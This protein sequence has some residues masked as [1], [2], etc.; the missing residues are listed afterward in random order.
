MKKF[1][2]YTPLSVLT[3]LL[4]LPAF[5]SNRRGGFGTSPLANPYSLTDSLLPDSLERHHLSQHRDTIGK[6]GADSTKNKV[7]LESPVDYSAKDSIVFE[8]GGYAHLFGESKVG[9]QKIKLSAE[10]ISMN[11]DSS[12]VYAHGIA[13][14]TG[15]IKGKPVF[16]DG[17][18]PYET[19][20]IRYNFDSKRGLISNIVT[21]QGEGYVTGH[22]AKKDQDNTICMA[23]GKYTT[24]DHHEH[25]HF[26]LQMTRAKVRPKKNVVTGPAYLVVE[27][28]PLPIWV[29]FFYFPFTNSYTSGF[30][31][32]T[33]VDDNDRGF[34]L[35]E[36]GY[37]WAISDYM[38][39]KLLGDIYTKGSW[40]SHIKLNYNKRYRYSGNFNLD[41]QV[42]VLGDK[43]LP[44]YSKANDF[45]LVWS[46]R[47][48]AKANPNSS[49]S[50]QV[51]FST[52]SYERTN[53]NNQYNPI[54]RSQNTKTSSVSYSRSFPEQ[55]LTISSTFNIA[56]TL[57]DSSVSLTLPDVNI[58][59]AKR[60]PF[61][62]KN[63]VGEE[64]WYEKIGMSYTGRITNSITC[65]DDELF[66]KSFA[67]DWK[68]GMNH[69]IPISATFTLFKYI[70]VTP[71]FNYRE[72]WYTRKIERSW[73]DA[74]YKEVQDTLTGF[75]RVWDY[76]MA[77]SANTKLYGMYKPLFFKK[78]EIQIRH[79]IT[80]SISFSSS[81]DF[82]QEKYGYYKH[83]TYVD[84]DGHEK[85]VDYS[86]YQGS[87][88]GIPGKGKSGTINFD[89]SN[90]LEMKYKT[91]RDSTGYRKVSLI[92][93]LGASISYN[94]AADVRP[95]SD[96]S[97]RL[98]LKLTKNYT[99][100]MN[101]TFATYAYEF[102]E[103]GNVVVGDKTEYSY[104]RFGRFQGWGSSFNYQF[105]NNTW[106]KWFGPKDDEKDKGKKDQDKSKSDS[107]GP[108]STLKSDHEKRKAEMS[109][110][111]YQKFAMPWSLNLN[112]SFN[113]REDRT[114][115]INKK[116]MR[117]PYKYTHNLNASGQVKL[118][119]NWN[120]NFS[121][122]YDFQ[123][124]EVTQTSFTIRRNLHCWE[125]SAS[126][127]PFG[128][129]QSYT[130][131]IR[132]SSQMLQD[133]KW[134]QRSSTQSNIEWY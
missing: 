45:K 64:R 125:M 15:K 67:K 123:A 30:L 4:L 61:K 36:G 8:K 6:N 114:K 86:P 102:D 74:A 82:G 76:N 3:L 130:F 19:K 20:Q 10:V 89:V 57:R 118:T 50:A 119:N 84:K 70:N 121:S 58:S 112:Y 35:Q 117:Y 44:D 52:S 100:N 113:I 40:A 34:G 101:S 62:R 75:Y 28:V 129:Y 134:D 128:R 127:T 66:E 7:G 16:E 48:D 46:H 87:A 5:A 51:N 99:F 126:V 120:I 39:L 2:R 59:L 49:F 47:Q 69:S 95:W 22:N 98:R 18:T 54:A 107:K 77:I 90:N 72:R 78:K 79:V 131:N 110:D 56:Q 88:F 29:P 21:Q 122:G 124:S 63:G 65:K 12:N 11:M 132:A 97:L 13:D 94:T 1:F 25:P 31:M 27:D 37:Y 55:K 93:E 26:Y 105:N 42:T 73:D 111:G 9:Y 23:D 32:P 106:K 33:Y 104:G 43:G 38:D 91:D 71:S 108:N 81:P 60:Y 53:L 92:D 68:N 14:S 115:D 103:N 109:S 41:Y 17:S 80:P 96:L 133:L 85:A 116:T 83:Y 24:C